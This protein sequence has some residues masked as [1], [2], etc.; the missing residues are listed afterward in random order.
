MG[1]VEEDRRVVRNH[2]GQAHAAS[3]VFYHC[4]S[5]A[6]APTIERSVWRLYF[7]MHIEE[8]GRRL[9]QYGA[10]FVETA[11]E[12]SA[13]CQTQTRQQRIAAIADRKVSALLQ[14]LAKVSVH[15]LCELKGPCLDGTNKEIA[16]G[17]VHGVQF[18]WSGDCPDG[19]AELVAVIEDFLI[20]IDRAVGLFS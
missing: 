11:S 19:M 3:R 12:G 7:D 15:S 10:L 4:Q 8:G 2:F 18:R 13:E 1:T 9:P 14:R 17:D 20:N 16:I 6:F 5:P